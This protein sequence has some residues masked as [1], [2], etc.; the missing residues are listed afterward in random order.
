MT[1]VAHFACH[2]QFLET[3]TARSGLAMSDGWLGIGDVEALDLRRLRLAMI[4]SCWTGNARVLPGNEAV[5]LPNA[6]LRAGAHAAVSAL[7]EV[8]Q[9]AGV[10]I[11]E[12]LYGAL[13]GRGAPAAL[14]AA[15]RG[16]ARPPDPSRSP[17]PASDWAG[18]ICY[19]RAVRPRWPG[20]VALAW[21]SLVRAGRPR[22]QGSRPATRS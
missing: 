17:R 13:A 9:D 2:G 20:R 22:L 4:A 7:W 18:L 3:P 5:A 12:R 11:A 8:P 16:L 1:E 19:Q 15:Q 6:F 21:R 14:A 10:E